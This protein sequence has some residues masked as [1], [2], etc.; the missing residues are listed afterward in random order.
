MQLPTT[1]STLEIRNLNPLT[2][3]VAIAYWLKPLRI[4]PY[5][6]NHLVHQIIWY[7]SKTSQR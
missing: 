5:H 2:V 3:Y 6:S 7:K 4:K 1:L